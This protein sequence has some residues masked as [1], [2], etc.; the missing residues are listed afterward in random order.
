MTLT[1]R[2]LWFYLASLIIVLAGFSTALYLAAREHLYRQ[3]DERLDAALNTLGAAVE[4]AA[5]GV[6]WEPNGRPI[7]LAVGPEPLAWVVTDEAGQVVAR[8]ERP[9]SDDLLTE[10]ARKFGVPAD[11]TRRVHW[12]GQRWQAGQRWFRPGEAATVPGL[13]GESNPPDPQEI[14]YPALVITAAL[15]LEPTRAVLH[16]LLVV[17]VGISIAVLAVALVAGRFVCRQALWPV[18]RMAADARAIDPTDPARRIDA[19]ADGDEL[20]DLGLSFNGLLDRLHESAERHRRFAGDASHQLRTPL[21][22]LLGQVEI[23][24]RRERTAGE[25]RD[26]LTS[27]HAQAT[28]L[29]RII[30]AL[31]YL[32]RAAADAGVPRREPLGLASWLSSQLQQWANHPRAADL[33]LAD[34]GDNPSVLSHPVL[35][36]E[37]VNVLID[38]ACRYSA[39]G[40]LITLTIAHADGL[41]RLQVADQGQGI[42]ANDLSQIFTPFFRT[43]DAMRANRKGMGLGLSIARR[44]AE[45][46]GG[47]LSVTSRVGC[48]SC[49]VVTLPSAKGEWGSVSD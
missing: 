1:N 37:V 23:A 39:A 26:A 25:Y 43:T 40:S 34:T 45:A 28:Q 2:L 20:T 30:E 3:A 11:A 29:H 36:G 16:N 18:R 49:F 21:A 13:P 5:D 9:G 22:A 47:N 6:E 7:R 32:T 27:A 4:V 14:K 31:L 24:L 42:S 12:R 38:N 41:A 17:L 15:P 8:S 10:A 33:H 48:G 44:L 46:L 19:P 35:L